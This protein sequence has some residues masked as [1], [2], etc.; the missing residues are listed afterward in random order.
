MSLSSRLLCLVLA[1]NLT[2]LGMPMPRAFAQ[3]DPGPGDQTTPAPTDPEKTPT[4]PEGQQ[5]PA[6]QPPAEGAPP[7]AP[8]AEQTGIKG[9]LLDLDGTT[10]IPNEDVRVTDKDGKEVAK[11]TSG[12]DGK[13][14]LPVLAEGGYVLETRGVRQP[15]EVKPDQPIKEL[16]I[17]VPAASFQAAG[18]AQTKEDEDNST[19]LILVGVGVAV[20]VAG[21]AAGLAIALTDDDEDDKFIGGSQPSQIGQPNT[22]VPTA[23]Q[24]ALSFGAGSSG[25]SLSALGEFGSVNLGDAPTRAITV[26]N[27]TGINQTFTATVTGAGFSL[28]LPGGGKA[29]TQTVVAPPGSTTFYVVFNAVM[30]GQASGT[31]TLV[32]SPGATSERAAVSE[33]NTLMI[34]LRCNV[35]NQ[36]SASPQFP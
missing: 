17:L 23:T 3:E 4:P 21:V 34:Q 8:E 19:V 16:K 11:A 12:P 13:F 22:G 15:F 9:Q 6:P 1:A 14:T 27:G 18:P 26:N 25:G 20:I 35:S 2:L 24:P 31:F 28:L 29:T 32:A 36:P 7:A 10:A 30:P 33:S 5:P